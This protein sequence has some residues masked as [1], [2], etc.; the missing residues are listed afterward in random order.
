M[1]CFFWSTNVAKCESGR[2]SKTMP[3]NSIEMTVSATSV[4]LELLKSENTPHW[5]KDYCTAGSSL[6]R[7]ALTRVENML[8]LVCREAV[9]SNLIK[10][11]TSITYSDPS[12]QR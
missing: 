11:E 6:T 12:P 1:R 3:R 10:L 2:Y 9:E 5:R 7:L 8:M 4:K